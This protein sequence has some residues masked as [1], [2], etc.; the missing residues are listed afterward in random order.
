MSKEVDLTNLIKDMEK[1]LIATSEILALV[2]HETGP[3]EIDKEAR[4]KIP[5][6]AGIVV[7]IDKE[8]NKVT[9]SLGV[10]GE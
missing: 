10:E 8:T 5:E 9:I 1:Q 4:S 3:V 2:L 6:G 7:D